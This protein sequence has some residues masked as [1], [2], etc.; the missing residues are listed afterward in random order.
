MSDVIAATVRR[1]GADIEDLAGPAGLAATSSCCAASPAKA[2][3]HS[4]RKMIT[5]TRVTSVRTSSVAMLLRC[6]R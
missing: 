1:N 6:F 4:Y 5:I 3:I 2:C